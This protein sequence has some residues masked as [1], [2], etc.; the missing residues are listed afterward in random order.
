MAPHVGGYTKKFK[1][2]IDNSIESNA[3]FIL[4]LYADSYVSRSR[5]DQGVM[6]G[7]RPQQ[8][9]PFSSNPATLETSQWYP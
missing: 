9:H 6:P 2:N 3:H 5:D 4:C 7:P 8:A 1:H